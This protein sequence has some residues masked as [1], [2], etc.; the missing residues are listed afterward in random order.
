MVYLLHFN[1]PFQ[2]TRHYIGY[3]D[4]GQGELEK[5]LKRHR[6]GSGSR[7]MRAVTKAGIGFEVARTWPEGDQ[8]FERRLK[9][10]KKA[11][12]Y[13]PICKTR[14]AKPH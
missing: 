6:A 13:C 7:L 2:H 4:G 9:N 3:V 8:H 11:S 5:R 10:M 12:Q 14:H 1:E